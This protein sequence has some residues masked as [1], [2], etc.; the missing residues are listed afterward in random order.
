[1][2]DRTFTILRYA[3]FFGL[4][5]FGTYTLLAYLGVDQ[6]LAVLL[7]DDAKNGMIAACGDNVLCREW[8]SLLPFIGNAIGRMS[9]YAWYLVWSAIAFAVLLGRTFLRDNE[10]RIRL[11]M[12]P[13]KLFGLFA[14]SVW[15]FFTLYGVGGEWIGANKDEWLP[16]R[17][18]FDV[19][20][21]IYP[22]SSQQELQALSD[23]LQSLK[24]R[25]CLTTVGSLQ[26]GSGNAYDMKMGCIQSSF[27]TRV[28]PQMAMVLV[29]FFSMLVLG[30]V[31]LRR[32][33]KVDPRTPFLEFAFS[34]AVGACGYMASLWLLA[35]LALLLRLPLYTMPVGWLL[36]LGIPAV[37]WRTSLE[38]L[39]RSWSTAWEYDAPSYGTVLL[40]SW[41]LL[42]YLAFNFLSVVRPFPIGWD[43][44]GRYLN[45]PHLLVSYGH[46]IPTMPTFQW[47]YITSLGYLL[48]GYDSYLGAT[49][50]LMM[51]WTAGVFA[52]AAIL[53]FGYAYLGVSGGIL[54]ALLYYTLPLVGHFSFAD[55]K[56]DNALFAIGALS[57]L[58]LFL[59]LFRTVADEEGDASERGWQDTRSWIM[60]AGVLG[61]FALGMKATAI[62]VVMTLG[63]VLVGSMLG[64]YGFAGSIF[65]SWFV[66]TQQNRFNV[67][68]VSQRVFGSDAVLSRPLVMAVCF[69]LG[70]GL[71]GYAAYRKSDALR[72]TLRAVGVLLA[73]FVASMLP[74]LAYNN[75]AND[76]VIPDL[77]LSV[78]NTYAPVFVIGKGQSAPG[79]TGQKV[80]SLPADLRVD[81]SNAACSS[82]ARSEELDR[83]W[84]QHAG[85]GHYL[86]L[87][88]RSVMNLDSAGYY[89]TMI[90]ALLLFPLLLLLPFFWMRQGRW[91]RWLFA[92]TAFL[93]LQWV[94]FANGIPWYGIGV[95]LGLVIAL[96]AFVA[97]APDVASAS[98]ASLFLVLSLLAS[99]SHRFWQYEQQSNI[100]EYPMG[101]ITAQALEQRTI[102]HYGDI[103][104]MVEARADDMPQQPYLYRIG[105]FIPY[106]IPQNLERIGIADQQLDFFNCLNQEKNPAL[107][108][109]RLQ[110]LGFN[111]VVFDTNTQTIEKDANG[112][113]HKKVN[114][115]VDFANTPNLGLSINVY[116][117]SAG[118]AYILLPKK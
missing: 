20:S 10:W 106:F 24:S 32:V 83:Y 94:F 72:P 105:T 117:P 111:S 107:T 104:R 71:L 25:G 110:A 11:R 43:D 95:F 45:Q 114:A 67:A 87:P 85:I 41:L 36:V 12:T 118:I 84:G 23:N 35:V 16:H 79:D 4:V 93:L 99:L 73:S 69:L 47:E 77:S 22:G 78:P 64:G 29:V 80:I 48:F 89:V 91:L 60:L 100:L 68:E 46:F 101:K 63:S 98:V 8:Y 54:A 27:V 34:L 56:I 38:W 37:F 58:A 31:L 59:G 108:L 112:S 50:S 66:Y 61:G 103:R 44:L 115:F 55:M 75:I 40:V 3:F 65:L 53:A 49:L 5:F 17:R 51:N 57:M 7:T 92:G 2:S 113:L 19:S 81:L 102:T 14:A 21:S 76:N 86:T 26:N 74:W 42:S 6:H 90:P 39:R 62:M 52:I 9:P 33:L 15:L 30:S 96:E 28:L 109:K 70:A 18:L 116:D 13:A 88:W 97:R 82:T 1:M